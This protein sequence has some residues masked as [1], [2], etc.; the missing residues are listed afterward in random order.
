[1]P[2]QQHEV[3]VV[4]AADAGAEPVAVVVEARDAARNSSVLSHSG[5]DL[6]IPVTNRGSCWPAG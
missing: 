3:A 2:E 1:V 5:I 4:A 6:E